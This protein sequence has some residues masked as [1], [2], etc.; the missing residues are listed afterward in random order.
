MYLARSGRAVGMAQIG[1][2]TPL[3]EEKSTSHYQ[4]TGLPCQ[5][6]RFL[7]VDLH[8]APFIAMPFVTKSFLF[9]VV[10]PGAPLVACLLR[11]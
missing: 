11:S 3:E 9:L 5:G 2:P 7:F 4:S 10:R 8:I 6:D 1:R